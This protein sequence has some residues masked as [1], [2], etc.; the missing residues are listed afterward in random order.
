VEELSLRQ[1]RLASGLTAAQVAR[2]AGTSEPNIAAYERG[3]KT[4]NPATLERIR[5]LLR[6]GATGPIFVNR[7]V[8]VPAAA[9]AVRS[10]LR[11]GWSTP[12]LL[13]IVRECLSNSKWATSQA[14]QDAFFSGPSTTGDRR[15]DAL[16]AGAV[17]D[18]FVRSGRLAPAWTRGHGLGR[19]W[20]VSG[21]R[22]FEAYSLAHS[23]PSLKVRG[24]MIDPDDLVSV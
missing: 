14:D 12:D 4:P 8:T 5:R 17:E 3:D 22:A 21:N 13:R 15:W 9:A 18:L 19:F 7:L 1:E 6:T 20:F 16:L 11:D 23:P 24:V 2:A 10:G